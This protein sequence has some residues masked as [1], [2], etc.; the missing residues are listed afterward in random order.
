MSRNKSNAARK[1]EAPT[2]V[3]KETEGTKP[4]SAVKVNAVA[5]DHNIEDLYRE[6]VHTSGVIR[7]LRSQFHEQPDEHGNL[8][9]KYS[10]GDVARFLGKLPQ[11]VRNVE[12]QVLKR[13]LA[14]AQAARIA[15]QAKPN[16]PPKE[17]LDA[18]GVK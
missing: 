12:L 1:Q 9:H 11:H 10:R 3:T 7:H 14:A 5:K 2:N 6:H 16:E 17:V 15:A 18:V 13:P 4:A 8:V